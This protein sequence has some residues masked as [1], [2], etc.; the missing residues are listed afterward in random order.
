MRAV[1]FVSFVSFVVKDCGGLGTTKSTKTTKGEPDLRYTDGVPGT[2][3]QGWK[4]RDGK[5]R[6]VLFVSFVSF[7]VKDC[8]GLGTTKGT[9]TTKGE[10]DLRYTDGESGTEQ[11]G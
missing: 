8:G 9:K 4:I 3:Q 6:A 5:M 10:S 7:V 1:L 2:E 11:Q